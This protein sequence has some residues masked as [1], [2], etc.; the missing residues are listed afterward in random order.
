MSA[1]LG[2][3][4]EEKFIQYA[5]IQKEQE[6]IKIIAFNQI[7][8]ENLEEVLNRIIRDTNSFKIPISINTSKELYNVFDVKANVNRK[9]IKNSINMAFRDVCIKQEIDIDSLEGRYIL[10][11]IDSIYEVLH[12]ST[13]KDDI[14]NKKEL[15]KEYSLQSIVPIDISLVNLLDKNDKENVAIINIQKN[16][17]ITFALN[18]QIYRVYKLNEGI[19]EFQ[20]LKEMEPMLHQLIIKIKDIIELQDISKIYITGKGT[21]NWKIDKY[22]EEYLLNIKC[23]ILKPFF[24]EN[25]SIKIPFEDYIEANPAIALALNGVGYV[26]EAFNFKNREEFFLSIFLIYSKIFFIDHEKHK[27]ENSKKLT[28]N[29]KLMLRI[30]M[31]F[32][33]FMVS[34]IGFSNKAY[35]RLEETNY[36]INNVSSQIHEQYVLMEKDLNQIQ[37]K[38]SEYSRIIETIKSLTE[39]EENTDNSIVVPKDAIPN[40]LN[41]I[42]NLIPQQ[43]NII[44]IKN[45]PNSKKIILEVESEKYEQLGYF[46]SVLKT[47]NILKDI[48]T[49][50]GLKN[51][52]YIRVTI[53]GDLP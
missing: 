7:V 31:V 39:V 44:S 51:G 22:F 4:I 17:T 13:E 21:R 6:D 19:N 47:E 42:M 12:V 9:E 15:L 33:I 23:E 48:K 35:N 49:T 10:R 8:Y 34:F 5:K 41:R 29:E 38:T 3:Y 28:A 46:S 37:E 25:N 50:S 14:N 11:K 27:K 32:I 52:E 53:E 18:G 36:A 24:L 16:T 30:C 43:V 40:M 45:E 1:C 2:I 20:D 26:Q